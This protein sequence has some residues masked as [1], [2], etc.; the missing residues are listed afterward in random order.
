MVIL[1][2]LV[3]IKNYVVRWIDLGPR[4][5]LPWQVGDDVIHPC[6]EILRRCQGLLHP[7]SIQ[8]LQ[9]VRSSSNAVKFP[10]LDYV[11][12]R[13]NKQFNRYISVL[14]LEGKKRNF[15]ICFENLTWNIY[16]E[17]VEKLA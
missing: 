16:N 15:C 12:V 14:T 17:Q 3:S 11:N 9:G 4:L 10:K 6:T 5:S 2:K 13:S 8:S 7:F 1:H